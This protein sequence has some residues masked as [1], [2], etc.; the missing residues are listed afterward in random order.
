MSEVDSL[1]SFTSVVGLLNLY[2]WHNLAT[3]ALLDLKD[4]LERSHFCFLHAVH[5]VLNR[6]LSRKTVDFL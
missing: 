2:F 4:D 3:S 1:Q 5:S 6:F